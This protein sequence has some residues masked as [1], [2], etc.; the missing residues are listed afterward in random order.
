M[1]EI[2][3]EYKP[4]L[5]P[6]CCCDG[7]ESLYSRQGSKL[8]PPENGPQSSLSWRRS[9]CGSMGKAR[10]LAIMSSR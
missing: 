7:R 6:S 9:D 5:T 3:N 4:F 2:E 1:S 10:A 8:M